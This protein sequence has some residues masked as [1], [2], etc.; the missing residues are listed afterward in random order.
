MTQ[1]EFKWAN[2][3]HWMVKGHLIPQEWAGDE[4][5]VK[6]VSDSY[7]RR[8]WGN[9]EASIHLVGFDQAWE[10]RYGITTDTKS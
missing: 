10:K 6:A 5:Q 7:I 9:H 3:L 2:Q 8:L 4:Q 1:A